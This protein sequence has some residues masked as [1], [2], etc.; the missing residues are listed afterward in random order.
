[1]LYIIHLCNLA[2]PYS[3]NRFY[4]QDLTFHNF[5]EEF[6]DITNI[7]NNE[8]VVEKYIES[9]QDVTN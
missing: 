7:K 5:I 1:M 3:I 9:L 8:T 4:N 2:F 6:F